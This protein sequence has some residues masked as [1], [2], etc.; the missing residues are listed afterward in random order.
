M[1]SSPG[2]E[3]LIKTIELLSVHHCINRVPQFWSDH[4]TRMMIFSPNHHGGGGRFARGFYIRYKKLT[5]I[6]QKCTPV[7]L[8]L[9]LKSKE[10]LILAFTWVRNGD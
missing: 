2:S 9:S 4:A 10:K 5:A 3:T 8:F 6:T 1:S 7:Q